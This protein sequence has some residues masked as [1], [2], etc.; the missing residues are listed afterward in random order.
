MRKGKAKQQ[1]TQTNYWDFCINLTNKVCLLFNTGNLFGGMAFAVFLVIFFRYPSGDLPILIR[2]FFNAFFKSKF[3]HAFIGLF[4]IGVLSWALYRT[5]TVK[6]KEIKRLTKLRK[7][8]IHGL[9]KGELTPLS[10][11][12]SSGFNPD[13]EEGDK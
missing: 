9:E 13:N 2:D 5:K 3:Y 12:H 10:T 7:D 8:L 6:D 4:I 11:H 1:K